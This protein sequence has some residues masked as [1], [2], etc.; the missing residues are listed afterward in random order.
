MFTQIEITIACNTK[1]F[2]CPSDTIKHTHM[3]WECFEKIVQTE[4]LPTMLLV[5]RISEPLLQLCKRY[6]YKRKNNLSKCCM[7]KK[8]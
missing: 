6:H 1:C 3:A 5:Q 7:I 2:Y 4:K 8:L